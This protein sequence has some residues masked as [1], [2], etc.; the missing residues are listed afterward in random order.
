MTSPGNAG[1][2]SLGP[3]RLYYAPLGTALPTDLGTTLDAAFK[4]IGYTEEGSEFS[5]ELSSDPVEV[6]ESLDPVFYRTTGRNGTVTFAMAENTVRNLTLAFNGGTVTRTAGGNV[7]YEPPEPGTEV[8]RVLVFDSEDREERWVFPQVFQGGSVSMARRKGAD[9]V[10]IP[11]EFRLE[12][13]ALGGAP[14]KAFY[15]D[16][17]DGG[18]GVTPVTP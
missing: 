17:R 11:A 13:P 7:S 16:D 18:S 4:P 8:R 6:A 5:Y 1:A 14:F 15:A 12:K 3:G 10:T 2:L 9:K